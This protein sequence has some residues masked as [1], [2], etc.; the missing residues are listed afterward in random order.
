MKESNA[1]FEKEEENENQ[2]NILNN[3]KILKKFEEKDLFLVSKDEKKICYNYLM[4]RIVVKSDTEK[5]KICQ[6]II[7]YNLEHFEESEDDKIILFILMKV[8]KSSNIQRIN[9]FVIKKE[10]DALI[11][12]IRLVIELNSLLNKNIEYDLNPHLIF[13][14]DKNYVKINLIDLALPEFIVKKDNIDNIDKIDKEKN[15][16]KE[17]NEEE[18]ENIKI[19]IEKGPDEIEKIKNK[20][21]TLGLCLGLCFLDLFSKKNYLIFF[22][23]IKIF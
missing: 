15:E 22:Q 10:K 16:I 23:R 19:N 5:K 20:E 11:I 14:D 13:I 12:F 1:N 21:K 7:K 3:Y 8:G 6:K 4:K 18:K 17:D 2:I 9:E